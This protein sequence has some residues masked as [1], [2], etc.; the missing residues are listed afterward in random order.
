MIVYLCIYI[1]LDVSK[2]HRYPLTDY[3][4]WFYMCIFKD[5]HHSNLEYIKLYID[6]L[7]Y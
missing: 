6:Y 1:H 2:R 3:S 4:P 7:E 5:R